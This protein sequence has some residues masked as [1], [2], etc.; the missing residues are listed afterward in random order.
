M[1]LANN[2]AF[3]QERRAGALQAPALSSS[4]FRLLS[5]HSHQGVMVSHAPVKPAKVSVYE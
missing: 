2:Q 4:T 5:A 1:M 3:P